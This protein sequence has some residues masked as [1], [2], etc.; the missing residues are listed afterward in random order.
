MLITDH[1]IPHNRPNLM[2]ALKHQK[3]VF[4]IDVAIPGDSRISQKITE[5]QKKYVDLKIVLISCGNQH[6]WSLRVYPYEFR[7]YA[8]KA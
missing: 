7:K 5:K 6:C 3:K 1:C 8:G 4:L 2:L